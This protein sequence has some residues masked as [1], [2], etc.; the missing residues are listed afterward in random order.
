MGTA[1]AVNVA[2]V[3]PVRVCNGVAS[4]PE[5]AASSTV[6][7]TGRQ[8]VPSLTQCEPA[9]LG[10]HD[11]RVRVRAVSLNYRDLTI[12]RGAHRRAIRRAKR[13]RG[14]TRGAGISSS[15]KAGKPKTR[16]YKNTSAA[17]ACA[18]LALLPPGCAKVA[19]QATASALPSSRGCCNPLARTKQ[20]AQWA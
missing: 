17:R 14:C 10:P 3:L 6:P 18:W 8:Y 19:N 15:H 5:P 11:V 16:R 20:A 4:D 12:A 9:A 7:L 13:R 2:P 1:A